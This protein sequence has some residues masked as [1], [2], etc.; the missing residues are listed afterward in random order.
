MSSS[1][2]DESDDCSDIDELDEDISHPS[3]HEQY[4]KGLKILGPFF[5]YY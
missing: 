3:S 4:L 2:D 5:S 1:S